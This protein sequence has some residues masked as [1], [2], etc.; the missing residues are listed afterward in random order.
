[1]TGT[2]LADPNNTGGLDS[3]DFCAAMRKLVWISS[4]LPL[5]CVKVT[6]PSVPVASVDAYSTAF[7][8]SQNLLVSTFYIQTLPLS[9]RSRLVGIHSASLKMVTRIILVPSHS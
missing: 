7:Q 1:M 2:Q 3:R 4:P 6:L 8:I 5:L 9:R